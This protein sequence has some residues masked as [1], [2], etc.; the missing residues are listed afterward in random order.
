[1]T[2]YSDHIDKL[3]MSPSGL[4]IIRLSHL[5][6]P[7]GTIWRLWQIVKPQAYIR[8]SSGYSV[9]LGSAY[10]SLY[11][12]S[13][14]RKDRLWSLITVEYIVYNIYYL[15]VYSVYRH[16]QTYTKG[17]R[18][19]K[20]AHVY[21]QIPHFHWLHFP[22]NRFSPSRC[23]L[24][25]PSF[26]FLSFFVR[27]WAFDISLQPQRRT[28]WLPNL[29]HTLQI[30]HF[31]ILILCCSLIYL[32]HPVYLF[33]LL[34][35]STT[36]TRYNLGLVPFDSPRYTKSVVRVSPA[37]PLGSSTAIEVLP[38]LCLWSRPTFCV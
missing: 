14:Q 34:S 9:L 15:E 22:S 36:C 21:T 1:M 35:G 27:P 4:R 16:S 5:V 13:S 29:P 25:L 26:L 20:K 30:R 8:L 17:K 32:A 23:F 2:R 7:C 37:T 3:F 31:S 11:H 24:F 19:Q 10:R 18:P 12:S 38:L 28:D 6:I 33:L